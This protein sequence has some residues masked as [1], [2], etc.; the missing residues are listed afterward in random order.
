MKFAPETISPQESNTSQQRTHMTASLQQQ[1]QLQQ[2]ESTP[3]QRSKSL[4]SAADAIARGIAGLG[5]GVASETSEIGT[6]IPEI[7]ALIE[8]A[9]LDPNQLNARSLM[10]LANHIMQRAVEGRRFVKPSIKFHNTSIL[11]FYPI[12]VTPCL[13][14]AFASRLLPKSRRR[15]FSRLCS[16]PVVNGIRNGTKFLA[17]RRASKT[18][19]DPVLPLLWRF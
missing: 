5:L 15:R 13:H 14:R 9:N 8:Q 18:V 4:S 1:Q 12:S 6:F 2:R 19:L 16:T 3:L 7:Q 10:E 11:I 17:H